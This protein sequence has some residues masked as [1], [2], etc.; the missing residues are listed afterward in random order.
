M[1]VVCAQSRLRGIAM[2]KEVDESSISFFIASFYPPIP[3]A[4]HMRCPPG[5]VRCEK[6]ITFVALTVHEVPETDIESVFALSLSENV[7]VF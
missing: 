5:V 2:K 1:F 3:N 7:A 6:I 4:L